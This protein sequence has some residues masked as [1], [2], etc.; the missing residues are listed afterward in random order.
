MGLAPLLHV[1]FRKMVFNPSADKAWINRDRFVLS[2]GHACSLLYSLLHLLGY[3]ITLDDLKSFRQLDSNTPG[4]PE[5]FETPGIEVTTGPLGQGFANAVGLAIGQ[6]HMAATYNR[7]GFDLFTNKTFVVLGDG[8][9][10]EGIASEAASLAGH[11][12]LGN[13][14][15]LYDDNHVCIDGDINSAFT[16][17]VMKRFEAY[18]W[19]VD[20]VSD[21]NHDLDGIKASIDRAIAHSN[22]PTLIKV[23]TTIGYGSLLQGTAACHGSP[24]KLDDVKQFRERFG[25]NPEPFTVSKQVYELYRN[26][27]KTGQ[28]AHDHWNELFQSY[29]EAHPDLYMSLARRLRGEL[30]K[31]WQKVLPIYNAAD[32]PLASRKLSELVLTAIQG[33]IPELLSG[34]ADLTTS[35]CTRWGDAVDFQAPET[36][37]G[38]YSGRYLRWGVREHAM[39]GAM[40][41]L[42][43]YGANIIPV[44]GTFLN[45]FSYAAGAVRLA[46]LSRQQVIWIATHDSIALGED[47]PTHQPIET[48]AHFRA[49]P[50]L[51]VWRPADGN[52]TSAAYQVA[53]TSKYTPSILALTRQNL[54]QLAASSISN[55][56]RGAYVCHDVPVGERIALTLVSTGSEVQLCLE[57]A[58]LLYGEHHLGIRVVSMP[59]QEIFDAQ[60]TEYRSSVLTSG[61]P[62]LSVEALSTQGWDKYSHQHFG[63]NTFGASGPS[64]RVFE[65][66]EMTVPG[67]KERALKTIDFYQNCGDLCSPLERAF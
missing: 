38:S 66:F 9:A 27:A 51:H 36:G 10:M 23:T 35:N 25:I 14:I 41:G 50:N 67:I 57:V 19:T 15:A 40:N 4:H 59:C 17:D 44:G 63:I 5:S 42:A 29:K 3:K 26:Y 58:K 47:G 24:L 45:F 11:L 52:E 61:C 62:I 49:M 13:L 56:T 46:C 8:C 31:D 28:V 65:K 48:L 7:S 12:R 60:G 21:G 53:L 20:H 33:I 22:K 2:N 1:L 30:P 64:E 37:L 55:A 32:A 18:G 39:V 34:S 16:E 6:A 43:A 54:P